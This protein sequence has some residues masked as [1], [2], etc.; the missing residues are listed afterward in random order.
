MFFKDFC[1]LVL[2][3]KVASAF[4]RLMRNTLS[5]FERFFLQVCKTFGVKN[6]KTIVFKRSSSSQV[7]TVDLQNSQMGRKDFYG[8]KG[9]AFKEYIF[10]S[11]CMTITFGML[12]ENEKKVDFLISN[13]KTFEESQN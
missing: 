8:E 12:V 1:I 5:I 10:C 3:T 4:E 6:C 9:I 2:R 7:W 11:N 13:S